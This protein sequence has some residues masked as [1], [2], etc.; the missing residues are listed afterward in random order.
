MV[1]KLDMFNDVLPAIDRRNMSFFSGLSDEEKKGFAPPVVLRFA[2]AVNDGPTSEHYLWLVNERAN[3]NFWDIADHPELQYKLIASCGY[4]RSQRHPWINMVG[5][6]KKTDRV[7]DFFSEFWPDAN[8][9]E[10]DIIFSQFTDETFE[11]FVMSSGSTPD[12]I[13]EI[14]EA[15]GRL[16]G[17]IVDKPK[18]K[19]KGKSSKA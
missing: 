1:H 10:L 4:G 5:K 3:I 12:I 14:L 6:T 15:Y 8:D 18:G 17:K 7:R 11:D 19:G 9:R 13:K 16:T 2:S